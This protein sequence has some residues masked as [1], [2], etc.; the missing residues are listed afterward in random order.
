MRKDDTDKFCEKLSAELDIVI[1]RSSHARTSPYELRNGA[2]CTCSHSFKIEWPLKWKGFD[3]LLYYPLRTYNRKAFKLT[4]LEASYAI[5]LEF[6]PV[7]KED[8]CAVG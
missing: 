4:Y 6:E 7:S 1:D 2:P 8:S 3:L 5:M